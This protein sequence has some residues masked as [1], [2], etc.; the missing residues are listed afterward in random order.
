MTTDDNEIQP[1]SSSKFYCKNCD[2]GTAKKCNYLDHLLTAKHIKTTN[3]NENQPK[4]SYKYKQIIILLILI[5][6][7]I[8]KHLIYNSF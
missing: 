2:Y 7:H 5:Q 4:S 8:I 3:N 6:I 1:K